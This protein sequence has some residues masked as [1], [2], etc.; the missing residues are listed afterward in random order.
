MKP[1]SNTRAAEILSGRRYFLE[2]HFPSHPAN[3][4]SQREEI[5]ALRLG[6]DAL[7]ATEK[8]DVH[9]KKAVHPRFDKDGID[10]RSEAERIQTR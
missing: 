3:Q 2:H 4:A 5:Y 1:M 10:H 8:N 6:A 9:F 7:I